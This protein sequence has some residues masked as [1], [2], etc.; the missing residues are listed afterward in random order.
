MGIHWHI[1]H[2]L[3]L[4]ELKV[5]IHTYQII[6][7]WIWTGQFTAFMKIGIFFSQS[8]VEVPSDFSALQTQQTFRGKIA[9]QLPKDIPILS[10]FPHW[11]NHL[12][13]VCPATA[14]KAESTELTK[15]PVDSKLLLTSDKLPSVSLWNYYW[16]SLQCVMHCAKNDSSR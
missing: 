2:P 4:S 11:G 1:P 12:C 3:T 13:H 8:K 9:T 7:P 5:W 14:L 16:M 6:D 15:F 10:T